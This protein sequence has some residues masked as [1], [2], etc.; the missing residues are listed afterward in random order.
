VETLWEDTRLMPQPGWFKIKTFW[1]VFRVFGPVIWGMMRTMRHPVRRRDQFQQA[2]DHWLN[3]FAAKFDQ[4]D[5]LSNYVALYEEATN[6]S[7]AFLL[8]RFI[9]VFGSG[10]ASLNL[11]LR[12]SADAGTDALTITRGLPH[13]VT[14]EMDLA[15]WQAAQAIQADAA[16]VSR[17]TTG[18]A[19]ALAEEYL[20]G[21]LPRAAQTAVA[22][23]LA[24]YGMRGLAEI[25][26][27]RPRWRENPAPIM[28]SLQS[29]L[30]ISDPRMAP[31]AVFKRGAAEAEAAVA[32]LAAALR[33]NGRRFKARL[34]PIAA[35]RVRALAG[36]RETPKFA[37]IRLF[38]MIR[39][40]FLK[41]GRQLVS[42][43]LLA[44]PDDLFYLRL[45]ELKAFAAAEKRDWRALIA[46]RRAA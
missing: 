27:G 45:D 28:Q 8:L 2:L 19:A 43:G 12:L 35:R 23:F 5:T 34:V 1:R 11:L 16:A 17:F 21:Q 36:L 42:D 3:N 41:H 24:Q 44:R 40:G 7:L 14:T 46:E 33:Q 6:N 32:S 29:Y 20:A 26:L 37:I 4:A 15:L 39:A 25:D 13:N 30:Q 38:G 18:S 9:P 31:D 22:R 10:M